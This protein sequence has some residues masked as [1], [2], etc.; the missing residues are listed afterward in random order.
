[1]QAAPVPSEPRSGPA[2]APDAFS[3]FELVLLNVYGICL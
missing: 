2:C 1:M 3:L